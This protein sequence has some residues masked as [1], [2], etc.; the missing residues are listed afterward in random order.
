MA[1]IIKLTIS[2][3]HHR[4]KVASV[5][6]GILWPDPYKVA[7]KNKLNINKRIRMA[8]ITNKAIF[9]V[10]FVCVFRKVYKETTSYL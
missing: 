1:N 2:V 10:Y 4:P 6:L 8:F 5:S 9:M 7:Q 3:P